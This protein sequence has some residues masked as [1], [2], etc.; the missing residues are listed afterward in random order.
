MQLQ[1]KDNVKQYIKFLKKKHGALAT[2]GS[3]TVNEAAEIVEKSY[4]KELDKFTLRNKFTK[5]AIKLYKSK[6]Q[7]STGEFRKI[8]KIN[9]IVAVRKMKG[10][11][12]HYLKMQEEGGTKRGSAKTQYSVAV[13]MDTARQG[14]SFAK[15]VKGP[16]RLQKS[17]IQKLQIGQHQL[18]LNDPF[19]GPQRWAILYKYTGLSGKGRNKTNPYG[20]DMKK[21]FFF[22]G[23][24]RG[25]GIFHVISRRIRMI[26]TLEK[27]FIRVKP[28]HKFKKSIGKI[29]T[30]I[31]G[32]IFIKNAKK[33][34]K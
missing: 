26:R 12:D 9:A 17:L 8:E 22:T 11:K 33:Y 29:T 21:Q 19:T 24:K 5:G 4:G 2:V 6:A 16:L 27:K 20:W 25:L 31:L 30:G 18:G 3:Q 10:G 14:G 23:M 34:L 15:P 32:N 1:Y 13:P 28:T 7:R